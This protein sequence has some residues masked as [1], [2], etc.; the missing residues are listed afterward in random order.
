MGLLLVSGGSHRTL[1]IRGSRANNSHQVII[2]NYCS[3]GM[4]G[5][6]LV[7]FSLQTRYKVPPVLSFNIAMDLGQL[8]VC[9]DYIWIEVFPNS[10][11]D[12]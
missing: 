9:G 12:R 3:K 6:N 4:F 1:Q 5:G 2:P 11:K 10:T 8:N 7:L